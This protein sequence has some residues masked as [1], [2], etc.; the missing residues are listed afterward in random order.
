MAYLPNLKTILQR[1]RATSATPSSLGS[2]LLTTTTA[3]PITARIPQPH[4]KQAQKQSLES[5]T[6]YTRK[7]SEHLQGSPSVKCSLGTLERHEAYVCYGK[8]D[9]ACYGKVNEGLLP[10]SI[11]VSVEPTLPS[12]F[13]TDLVEKSLSSNL[14]YY[15]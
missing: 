15:S 9:E 2:T 1:L 12:T 10:R 3:D 8:V 5:S 6:P 4:E 14:G 13:S 7:S 11:T